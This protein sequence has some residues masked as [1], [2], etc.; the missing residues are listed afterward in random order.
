MFRCFQQ[1]DLRREDLLELLIR[2][3]DAAVVELLRLDVNPELLRHLRAR[4][5]LPA[6]DRRQALAQVHRG[7]E[8][9]GSKAFLLRLHC[10]HNGRT[11]Q[12]GQQ[13][14]CSRRISPES[15]LLDHR[16]MSVYRRLEATVHEQ[17][18]N[19]ESESA[20]SCS[21]DTVKLLKDDSRNYQKSHGFFPKQVSEAQKTDALLLRR[22]DGLL[23]PGLAVAADLSPLRSLRPQRQRLLHGLRRLR[24]RGLGRRGLRRG[25]HSDRKDQHAHT[26]LEPDL[27]I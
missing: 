18:L 21:M 15:D 9:L 23:A 19:A 25:R 3:N 24:N 5:L 8:T 13:Q 2:G 14:L 27:C 10:R 20:Q 12:S 26:S 1:A 4:H 17:V 6:A 7:E 16:F 11:E 22:Q